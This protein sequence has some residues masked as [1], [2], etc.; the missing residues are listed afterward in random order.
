MGLGVELGCGKCLYNFSSSWAF[1]GVGGALW[2]HSGAQGLLLVLFRIYMGYQ[3]GTW[4]TVQSK[5]PT[6]CTVTLAPTPMLFKA[7]IIILNYKM[8]Y[9]VWKPYCTHKALSLIL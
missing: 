1:G 4:V 6:C 7:D 9:S 3:D 8:F 5:H 2:G